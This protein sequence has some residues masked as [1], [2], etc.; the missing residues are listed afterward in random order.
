LAIITLFVTVLTD[1]YIE[2]II[3]SVLPQDFTL[4]SLW[5]EPQPVIVN[6]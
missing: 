1:T 6:D 2:E 4:D 5:N 3:E